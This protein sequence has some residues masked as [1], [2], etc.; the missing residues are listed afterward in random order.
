MTVVAR[1]IRSTPVRTT[2]DTWTL[3]TALVAAV[4]VS[5]RLDLDKAGNIAAMLIAEEHTRANP[6]LLTGCGPQVRIYTLHGMDAIDGVNVNEQALQISPTDG[7]NLSLPA[8]GADFDLAAA[9]VADID[10]VTVYETTT[11]TG[12]K[13]A[14]T[15]SVMT[16]RV[17]VDLT[18]L[19]D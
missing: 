1:R 6:I 9:A 17:T 16:R 3:I 8:A 12:A 2:A 11:P 13:K 5:M 18:A 14:A 4:D 7:W 10:H 19:E 15:G